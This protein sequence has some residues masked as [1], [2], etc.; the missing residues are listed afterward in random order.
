M[1]PRLGTPGLALSFSIFEKHMALK[2]YLMFNLKPSFEPG[3]AK[4]IR[5]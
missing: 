3:Y 5:I 4:D 1:S 2:V